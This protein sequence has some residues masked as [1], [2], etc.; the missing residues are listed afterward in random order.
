MVASTSGPSR[1]RR[2]WPFLVLALAL[3]PAVWHVVDFEEDTDPELPWVT[4]PTFSRVPPAAY[5]LAE[6]GDTLDRIVLYLAAAG[7]ILAAI[8][9]ATSR[10]TGLWPA[11][12]AMAIGALWHGATPG[13]AFDGWHG[14][15]F[16]AIV[17][18]RA[19]WLVR[20]GLTLGVVAG[21]VAVS[22]TVLARRKSLKSY[23]TG[24]LARGRAALWMTSLILVIG[25]QVEIP[26]V[27]PEG[28]WPRWC[29]IWGVLAFDLALSIE[30]AAKLKERPRLSLWVP[31]GFAGWLALVMG[32]IWLTWCHRPLARLRVVE[33]GRIYMSAMPTR[34]GL[35]LAQ[36]RHHFRTIIN[37][38]P[39][40]TPLRSPLLPDELM[41][42]RAHGIRYVGSPSSGSDATSS[43]F[44]DETLALAQ[45]P[46]AWPILVHCHGCMDRTPAW[47]GIYRFLVQGRPLLEIMQQIE[48]HRGYRPWASVIVLYNRVLSPR[49]GVRYWADPTAALLRGCAEGRPGAL[50]TAARRELADA[51]RRAAPR[52][53]KADMANVH[54]VR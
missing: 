51:N 50:A 40:D 12:L 24:A 30:L 7:V 28:Y 18:P 14:L 26:G 46:A 36:S 11:G 15:G 53:G 1:L 21:V 2:L 37:F 49:G 23:W 34:L 39:E 13:P 22:V 20:G 4:R 44:L 54:E 35:E 52:V 43:Q 9:T 8:G 45:D 38:F 17:D 25:R 48:R 6:P 19:G 33:P 10:A 27:E 5:R 32:G 47:V 42:A 41:F 29:L 31:L 3:V 16:R